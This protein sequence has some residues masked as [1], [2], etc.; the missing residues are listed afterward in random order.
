MDFRV[1]L[2]ELL[3]FCGPVFLFLM[4]SYLFVL[5]NYTKKIN[6]QLLPEFLLIHFSKI[7]HLALSIWELV[8]LVTS[9]VSS[10][11]HSSFSPIALLTT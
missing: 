8:G 9:W 1:L 5:L 7:M 2:A 10:N 3:G 6:I 4:L 11:N